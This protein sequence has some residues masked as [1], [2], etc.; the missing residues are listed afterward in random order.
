M[1]YQTD[2]ALFKEKDTALP[3]PKEASQFLAE[4]PEMEFI[5]LLLIDMNGIVRGKRV[6]KDKLPK[7][8]EHGIALP[9]SIYGMNIKGNPVEETGLGLEIGESDAIC[10]PVAGSLTTQPWQKRP[11]AQL[12]LEM[13]EDPQTPFFGDPRMILRRL[14]RQI[15]DKGLTPVSAFELEFYLIDSQES[16][17]APLPPISPVTGRRPEN[18]QVYSLDDLDEYSEFLTGIIDAAREQGLPADTIVAESAPGQF[19]INLTHTNDPL[20][21]CDYALL[22]K[23]VIKQVAHEHELDTTFMAKPYADQAGNGM[24]VHI[25]LVDEEG[26]NVFQ[27]PEDGKMTDTLRWA[28]GGMLA[29]MPDYMAIL[30]PNINSFRRFSPDFYVPNA[31]TWGVENRTT[32][33][34]I[35]GDAPEATRIEHRVA[36]ADAN[37]YLMMSALLASVLYG[38]ENKIEPSEPVVGNAY[39]KELEFDALPT[40]LRDALRVL[41]QSEPMREY[42]GTDFVDVFVTCKEKELEEFEQHITGLEYDWYLHAF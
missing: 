13:Y 33:L 14:V 12:L 41:S 11:I 23:R 9:I 35:P 28:L 42:L 15:K 8:Y 18:T 31:A 20:A 38:I 4:H 39:D 30:C 10:F 17:Q 3:D 37:P 26:N 19:E 29:L 7:A 32:A 16:G 34:R 27:S 5:D 25:S 22:L 21:A 40:N 2:K 6:E 36:G 1:R 24:H